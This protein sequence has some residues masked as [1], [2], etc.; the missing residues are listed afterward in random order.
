M[1]DP[2]FRRCPVRTAAMLLLVW[3]ADIDP[4]PA[5]TQQRHTS[6]GLKAMRRRIENIL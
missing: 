2:G 5:Q 3:G 4:I 1:Q 6:V